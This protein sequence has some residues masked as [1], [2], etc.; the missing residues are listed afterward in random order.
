MVN[1][2]MTS[3]KL[4]LERKARN[5]LRKK[6]LELAGDIQHTDPRT[7]ES[8]KNLVKNAP[9]D[10]LSD[11]QKEIRK[12]YLELKRILPPRAEKYIDFEAEK[13][14]KGI[15]RPSTR[16]Y[17]KIYEYGGVQVF[18]DSANID[19]PDYKN[20]IFRILKL[21]VP[22]FL[23]YIK[24]IIPNR[25]PKFIITD[26]EKNP[27]TKDW[28]SNAK[29]SFLPSGMEYNKTIFI[30]WRHADATEYYVHE[31]AHWVADLVPALTT[32]KLRE[33]FDEMLNDYFRAIKKKPIPSDK[34]SDRIRHNIARKLGYP[35]IYGLQD[36]D[37][38]FAVTIEYWRRLPTN[39][40]TYKF[41]TAMK[42]VI[43]LL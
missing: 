37:E 24:G 20:Y 41:K 32:K 14:Q 28:I 33:L 1:I 22:D 16:P 19:Y 42:Q 6:G 31:Y 7:V 29:F 15:L 11:D 13:Y 21:V 30:D 39:R 9:E 10:T 38:F 2:G 26:F 3:F 17:E 8:W 12:K 23:K 34:I 5:P 18:L 4:F 27:Q 43:T 36:P 35:D 40:L 25:K